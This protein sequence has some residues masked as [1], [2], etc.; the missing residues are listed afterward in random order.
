MTSLI[1][2]QTWIDL[3]ANAFSSSGNTELFD[4]FPG[5]Q[6]SDY[7][8]STA[9]R[10]RTLKHL[11]RANHHNYAVM[12]N[13]QQFHNHLPHVRA[14]RWLQLPSLLSHSRFWG[15]HT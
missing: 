13:N 4:G 2:F 11:L 15:R 14:I 8:T 9:K 5:V 1:S 10:D 7:E 6:P 12:Y 3:V